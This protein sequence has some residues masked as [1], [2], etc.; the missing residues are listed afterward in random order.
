MSCRDYPGN[1]SADF[2]ENRVTVSDKNRK[3]MLTIIMRT[4]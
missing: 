4:I 3:I 1:Y 2:Y